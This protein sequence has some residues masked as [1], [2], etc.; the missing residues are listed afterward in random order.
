MKD[1]TGRIM[2]VLGDISPEEL[3]QTHM[4]EHL[5]ID[6]LTVSADKQS[7]HSA[8]YA[9]SATASGKF[10]QKISLENL[11]DAR[12]NP[13]LFKD[14]LQ[15]N[16]IDDAIRSM[17]EYRYAGGG[18]L[19]ELTPMGAGRDPDGLRQIAIATGINVVMGTGFYVRDYQPASVTTS[20][21]EEIADII[22]QDFTE[23]S[24]VAKVR[25]G[26]IGEVGLTWPVH[27]DEEKSL[28]GATLAQARTGMSITVHPGRNVEAPRTAIK[29]IEAAGG[30]VSR[31]V[32]GHLDRTLFS[33]KAM[34]DFAAMGCVLEFDLFGLE[35]CYYPLSHIDMPNDAMRVDYIVELFK[36]GF[37]TQVTVGQDCDTKTRMTKYGGEGYQHILEHVVPI[38]LRKGLSEEDVDQVLVQTPR[39]LLTLASSSS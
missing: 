32:M 13:F 5:L 3:G 17:N 29:I 39:R 16:N 21:A 25:P 22:V 35:S 23:G 8:A 12:R 31:V 30:D 24:G 4:H 7:S 9:S 1:F 11:Y 18:G 20:S 6:F 15:L 10:E 37:G 34:L 27:P 19:V 33:T 36:A 14:T 28:V 26:I 2:T 38:M